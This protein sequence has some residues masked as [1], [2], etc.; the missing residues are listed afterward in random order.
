MMQ[1]SLFYDY[2]GLIAS[3]A[4]CEK[5]STRYASCELEMLLDVFEG[6]SSCELEMLLDVFEGD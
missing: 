1:N 3:S 6:D 2:Y 4:L 5:A